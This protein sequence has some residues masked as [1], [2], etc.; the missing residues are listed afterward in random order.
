MC[1]R[2][3]AR[4][5]RTP[6]RLRQYSRSPLARDLPPGGGVAGAGAAAR[7]VGGKGHGQC[8]DV[9]VEGHEDDG[10]E[11]AAGL[12]ADSGLGDEG[13]D[14]DG[15]GA[16]HGRELPA[17]G[18][19]PEV[20]DAE[21]HVVEHN[22]PHAPGAGAERQERHR[23]GAGGAGAVTVGRVL[24]YLNCRGNQNALSLRQ[25]LVVGRG[26]GVRREVAGTLKTF[27]LARKHRRP[28]RISVDSPKANRNA[29]DLRLR[30]MVRDW[31]KAR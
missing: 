3:T 28:C 13:E 15:D 10:E 31:K 12:G 22:L 24:E 9:V 21:V 18:R 26:R 7:G 4:C 1:G 30:E 27:R 23:G 6:A 8:P 11:L 17:L 19:L 2:A 5:M 14:V 16:G 20:A 29:L 25:G